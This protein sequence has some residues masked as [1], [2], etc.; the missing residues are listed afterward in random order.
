M[1]RTS[2]KARLC[3]SRVPRRLPAAGEPDPTQ[4]TR[5]WSLWRRKVEVRVGAEGE[6]RFGVISS[7]G[8]FLGSKATEEAALPIDLYPGHP[9]TPVLIP[10]HPFKAPREWALNGI[11]VDRVQ[12]AADA[13][14]VDAP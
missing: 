9:F 5:E 4:R 1:I 12:G 8:F 6:E 14:E 2:V 7:G 13:N 11:D 10:G 3:A